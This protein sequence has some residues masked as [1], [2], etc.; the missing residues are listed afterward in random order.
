[1][2]E[3]FDECRKSHVK[4]KT[5]VFTLDLF[6]ANMPQFLETHGQGKAARGHDLRRK[7]EGQ[8]R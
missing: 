3:P 7:A 5:Y 1:M 4:K 2:K 6:L 8:E